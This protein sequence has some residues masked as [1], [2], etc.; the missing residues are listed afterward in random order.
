MDVADGYVSL[1]GFA[2]DLLPVGFAFFHRTIACPEFLDGEH[3]QNRFGT[4]EMVLVGMCDDEG[5]EFAYANVVQK[6][7]DDVFAGILAAIVAGI[8]EKMPSGWRFDEVAIALPDIDGRER[9][10][11]VQHFAVAFKREQSGSD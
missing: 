2:E 4:A 1:A 9:P 3:F 10:R 8:D 7:Y 6:W 11:R 5:V